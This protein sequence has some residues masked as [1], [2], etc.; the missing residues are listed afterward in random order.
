MDA[1]EGRPVFLD[2]E[3]GD[4]VGEGVVDVDEAAPP[5]VELVDGVGE[6]EELRSRYIYSAVIADDEIDL[7]R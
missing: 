4:I 3:T 7:G 2:V 5:L 6:A 1:P